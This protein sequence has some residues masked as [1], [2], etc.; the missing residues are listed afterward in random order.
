MVIYAEYW[1]SKLL[2]LFYMNVLLVLSSFNAVRATK[3][4]SRP[5]VCLFIKSHLIHNNLL[6]RPRMFEPSLNKI[7]NIV[8]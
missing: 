4:F 7:I 5:Q 8:G 3:S 6:P 1:R 2:C